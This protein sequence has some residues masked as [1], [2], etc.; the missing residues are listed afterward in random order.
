MRMYDIIMKKRNGGALSPREIAFFVNGYTDGS[1][2]DYQASALTM[3]IYY[4]GMTREETVNL[5]LAMAESGDM[6]D[7]SRFE[8]LSCDKHSTGG[9][10]DKTTLIVAPTVAALGGKLAKNASMY[11]GGKNT[12]SSPRLPTS[13][14]SSPESMYFI[15]NCLL[16]GMVTC[17][18]KEQP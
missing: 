9:V 8:K 13:L 11:A 18:A 10:G 14:M 1:I 3:A 7:L 15:K 2:P 4:K 12:C 5:T 6:V 16:V 17:S